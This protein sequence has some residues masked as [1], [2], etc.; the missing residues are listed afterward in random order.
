MN[1]IKKVR[2]K[3]AK[4]TFEKAKEYFKPGDTVTV[5]LIQR[6]CRSGYNSATSVYKML[7]SKGLTEESKKGLSK[8]K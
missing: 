8:M 3:I 6:Y 7:L 4:E 1:A 5:S 2:D